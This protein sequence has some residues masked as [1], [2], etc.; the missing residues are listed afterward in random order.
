MATSTSRGSTSRTNIS[1]I[2]ATVCLAVALSTA[3]YSRAVAPGRKDLSSSRL[4]PGGG[5]PATTSALSSTTRNGGDRSGGHTGSAGA[6]AAAIGGGSDTASGLLDT[7]NTAVTARALT[8]ASTSTPTAASASPTTT[9]SKQAPAA[10]PPTSVTSPAA[11]STLAPGARTSRTVQTC[12][13]ADIEW[14]CYEA[15]LGD[16][17]CKNSRECEDVVAQAALKDYRQRIGWGCNLDKRFEAACFPDYASMCYKSR[18]FG[19]FNYKI[20]AYTDDSCAGCNA[21][22]PLEPGYLKGEYQNAENGS[23]IAS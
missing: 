23:F 7:H 20:P 13:Y 16:V 17:P 4:N 11:A 19:F 12:W 18:C 14:S 5:D 21:V 6:D 1:R 2:L 22:K 15:G 8:A 3:G 9:G 10:S